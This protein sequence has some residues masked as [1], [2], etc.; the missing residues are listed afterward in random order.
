MSFPIVLHETPELPRTSERLGEWAALAAIFLLFSNAVVVAVLYHGVP[1]VGA[2]VVPMFLAIP[3]VVAI[4]QRGE[5]L[6]I[7]PTLLWA[8]LYTIVQFAGCLVSRRPIESIAEWSVLLSEGLILYL[9]VSNALRTESMVRRAV[10]TLLTAGALMGALVGYQQLT[11]SFDN[12]FLGFAQIGAN[13]GKDTEGADHQARLAGP[14]GE[15]NSFAQNMAMLI[16]LALFALPSAR[17]RKGKL[18][19]G[20]AMGLAMLAAM[21]AFSRGI[22]VGLAMTFVVMA[23][24]GTVR[25]K[26]VLLA[27]LVV[28]VALAAVPRYAERL[29]TLTN[30]GD[31]VS[32]TGTAGIDSS[33]QGRIT[34]MLA[35]SL[36][37]V[38]HP[39][40]G[41]GPGMARHLYREYGEIVGGR[42]RAGERM[43]HSLYLQ[44]AAEHGLLGLVT[45]GGMIVSAFVALQRARRRLKRSRPDLSMLVTGLMMGLVVYLTTGMFLH[46][47]YVRYFWLFLGI[48]GAASDVLGARRSVQ[49]FDG[50]MIDASPE[51]SR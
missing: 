40:V 32:G 15:V 49:I 2:A 31:L 47:T 42:L 35:A 21:L 37:F 38:D 51:P 7:S 44:I 1:R 10:F 12:E 36:V 34:E 46:T 4:V 19:V 26:H 41:A 48:A 24:L 17:T 9:L 27:G 25:I 39:I 28:A 45:F 30:F 16:P 22:A 43:A 33:S 11:R 20:A 13:V 50:Y 5:G 14:I 8:T 18:L 3:M 6:R 29:T 23:C